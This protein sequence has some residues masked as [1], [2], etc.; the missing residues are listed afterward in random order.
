MSSL[1]ILILQSFVV[2]FIIISATV[3]LSLHITT[4]QAIAFIALIS[5]R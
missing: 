3:R 1:S 2:A 4:D 5:W